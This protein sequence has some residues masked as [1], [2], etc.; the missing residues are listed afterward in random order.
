[1]LTYSH[2]YINP[3][4]YSLLL[5]KKETNCQFNDHHHVFYAVNN[6]KTIMQAT[7]HR[8]LIITDDMCKING[9]WDCRREGEICICDVILYD[10]ITKYQ[11]LYFIEQIV[12]RADRAWNTID[13]LIVS[14]KKLLKIFEQFD[15][16]P[17]NNSFLR[18]KYTDKTGLTI[19]MYSYKKAMDKLKL[20]IK[21]KLLLSAKSDSNSFLSLVPH[22]I[23]NYLVQLQIVL[24]KDLFYTWFTKKID[25]EIV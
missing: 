18:Y 13:A 2:K 24:A 1:M 4:D 25:M 20:S 19:S 7:T 16:N 14:C 8:E 5:L 11:L 21:C 23:I 6:D 15:L 3:T 9:R 12:K 10:E 22:D 17:I